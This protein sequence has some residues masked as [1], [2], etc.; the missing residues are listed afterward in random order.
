MEIKEVVKG[1]IIEIL[2]DHS[3]MENAIQYLHEN[4]DLAK[5]GMN[6]ISFISMVVK[7]EAEFG[8]EFED[9]ALDYNKFTSLNLLCNYVEDMMRVNNV[10]YKPKNNKLD[11]NSMREI[12]IQ[13]ISKIT[14]SP[15]INEPSFND[16]STLVI[17]FPDIQNLL[18][19]IKE[20][21]DVSLNEGVIVQESLFLLDNLGKY[22]LD[23]PSFKEQKIIN[24]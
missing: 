9:E 21:F 23:H 12:L 22:I 10:V 11:E 15:K 16:L 18:L 6:S 2:S 1:K 13:M 24:N 4:D 5:L 20:R 14:D 8:F 7:L 3:E 17:P 19:D